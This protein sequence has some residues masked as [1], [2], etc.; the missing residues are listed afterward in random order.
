M[1][2]KSVINSMYIAATRKKTDFFGQN[3]VQFLIAIIFGPILIFFSF[4]AD[5]ISLPSALL[6]DSKEFERKY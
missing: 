6:K 5:L 1:Y 2:I 4:V 3:I